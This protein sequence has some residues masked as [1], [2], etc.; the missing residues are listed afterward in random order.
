VVAGLEVGLFVAQQHG[1]F[2]AG[3]GAEH[4][5]GHHDAAGVGGTRQRS[6]QA[7]AVCAV[8]VQHGPRAALAR[9]SSYPSLAAAL[10]LLAASTLLLRTG[11]HQLADL[12][13]ARSAA[14]AGHTRSTTG[15][16]AANG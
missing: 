16:L 12:R 14:D 15:H 6:R 8:L 3:E 2:G 4:P 7:D 9:G 1:A 13:R 5:G 10:L 11:H